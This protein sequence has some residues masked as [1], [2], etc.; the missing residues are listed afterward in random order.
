VKLFF[1]DSFRCFEGVKIINKKK[2]KKEKEK[3]ELELH[4]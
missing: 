2:I 4:P 1:R 3:K